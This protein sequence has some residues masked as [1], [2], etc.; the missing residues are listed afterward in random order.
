MKVILLTSLCGADVSHH[1]GD[2]IEVSNKEALNL[3]DAGFAKPKNKKELEE[4]KD[5]I[6]EDEA[7]NER[8]Q[9]EIEAILYKEELEKE[10]DSL[11]VRLAEINAIIGEKNQDSDNDDDKQDSTDS[12]KDENSINEQDSKGDSDDKKEQSDDNSEQETDKKSVKAK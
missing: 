5:K 9:A 8:K 7:E 4:L 2:E 3:I 6:A 11:L 10:R 1:A 12:S